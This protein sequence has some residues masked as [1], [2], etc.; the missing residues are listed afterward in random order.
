[1]PLVNIACQSGAVQA[2][3]IK[4]E[5]AAAAAAGSSI[6][7][8]GAQLL[9][10]AIADARRQQELERAVDN[11]A[12]SAAGAKGVGAL[13]KLEAAILAARK[14]GAHEADADIYKCVQMYRH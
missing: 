1:M 2:E 4:G 10:P 9:Q 14:A 7:W 6:V 13:Q 5:A 12:R 8:T 3:L 11:L